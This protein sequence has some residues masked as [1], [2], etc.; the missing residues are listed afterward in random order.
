MSKYILKDKIAIPCEDLLEWSTWI[1]TADRRVKVTELENNIRIS[2]VFLGIS[3][4]FDDDDEK[5][6]LFETMVFGGYLHEDLERCSTWEEAEFQHFRM[7]E[8][9]IQ[10]ED[11]ERKKVQ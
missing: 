4:Q 8:K 10:V 5:S 11:V 7:V 9:V 1:E 6:L 2:T 3:Y